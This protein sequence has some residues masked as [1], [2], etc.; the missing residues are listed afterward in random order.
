M[1][2]CVAVNTACMTQRRPLVRFVVVRPRSAGRIHV[3]AV[4]GPAAL[5][6]ALGTLATS[7]SEARTRRTNE[8]QPTAVSSSLTRLNVAAQKIE[9]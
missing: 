6:R 8:G 7:V 5:A 4:F 2:L 3:P 1:V 9:G